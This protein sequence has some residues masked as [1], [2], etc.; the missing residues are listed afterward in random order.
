VA[1]PRPEPFDVG[2]AGGMLGHKVLGLQLTGRV[3]LRTTYMY[4]GP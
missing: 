3:S 4:S 2:Q 1:R